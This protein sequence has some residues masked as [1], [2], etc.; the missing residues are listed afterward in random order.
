MLFCH[1]TTQVEGDANP[2]LLSEKGGM[3]FPHMVAMDADGN[4]LAMHESERTADAFAATM[5][6]ARE[7][8]VELK[9]LAEQ[10]GKGDEKAA[11]VLFEKRLGLAHIA[12]KDAVVQMA[13][14]KG[15]TDEQKA[16]LNGLIAK[17]EVNEQLGKLTQDEKTHHAAGKAFQA[18]L[19]AGRIPPE[20]QE[21]LYFWYFI[22]VAGHQDKDAAVVGRALE[23]VKAMSRAPQGLVRDLEGKLKELQPKDGDKESGKDAGK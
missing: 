13:A 17:G 6:A 11:A 12:P 21:Q 4:V 5:T 3:G 10:A 9:T 8:Q 22:A 1:V 2:N 7:V 16:T 19:A 14:L 23:G 18:M 20:G 15:L